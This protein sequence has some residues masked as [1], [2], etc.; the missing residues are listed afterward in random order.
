M[1]DDLDETQ[2]DNLLG[3]TEIQ[4]SSTDEALLQMQAVLL[5]AL[6]TYWLPRYLI[7]VLQTTPRV[8]IFLAPANDTKGLY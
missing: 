8:I 3:D 1:D 2:M 5:K 7:H 4:S 6:K